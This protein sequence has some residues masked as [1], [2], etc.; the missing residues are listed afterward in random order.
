MLVSSPGRFNALGNGVYVHKNLWL[1][2]FVAVLV[3]SSSPVYAQH[4][5]G[6]GGN[7]GG[8]GSRNSGGGA[9]RGG[10]TGGNGNRSYAVPRRG[11]GDSGNRNTG[12]NR[13]GYNQSYG[14]RSGY[15]SGGYYGARSY[16]R[17][18]NWYGYYGADGL[19]AEVFDLLAWSRISRY[20]T[21]AGADS[22]VFQ[23]PVP[24]YGY[25]Q[26]QV[27]LGYDGYDQRGQ[28]MAP[29]PASTN[30]VYGGPSS[31]TPP[32][33]AVRSTP[34]PPSQTCDGKTQ[35]WVENASADRMYVFITDGDGKTVWGNWVY[36]HQKL[37]APY[38][39]RG[40]N[41]TGSYDAREVQN[42]H[43]VGTTTYCRIN[44]NPVPGF[45]WRSASRCDSSQVKE[46]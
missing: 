1:V 30:S 9:N 29:P 41:I 40:W 32:Q 7:R 44:L 2:V 28:Q 31:P 39:Q 4:H 18:G 43:T 27:N 20:A 46:N 11:Y 19:F 35:E 33:Y 23:Q 34:P 15:P 3:V 21:L 10:N 45:G 5:S 37:C 6:G 42:E 22:W 38:V 36:S 8:G 12:A 17:R 25:G 24:D 14:W 26:P 16:Y 13:G